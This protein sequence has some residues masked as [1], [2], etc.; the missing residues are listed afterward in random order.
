M[1]YHF[2]GLLGAYIT[3]DQGNSVAVQNA[4]LVRAHYNAAFWQHIR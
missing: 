2:E 4:R 1:W 3:D